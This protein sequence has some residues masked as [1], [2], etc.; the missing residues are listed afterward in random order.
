M[1]WFG[2]AVGPAAAPASTAGPVRADDLLRLREVGGLAV[3]PDGRWLA[4][5]VRQADVASNSYAVR[6]FVQATDGLAPP[7]PLELDGGQPIPGYAYG[8][9]AGHIPKAPPVWSPDGRRFAFRRQVADRVELWASGLDGAPPVRVADGAPQVTEFAWLPDGR[10]VYRTGLNASRYAAELEAESANGWLQD[11]RVVPFASQ[12]RPALPE[13]REPGESPACEIEVRVDSPAGS[14]AAAASERASFETILRPAAALAAAR[15][16]RIGLAV[17][18]RSDGARA[19]TET[20]DAAHRD[21]VFPVMALATDAAAAAPCAAAACRAGRVLSAGWGRG[22]REIW[23]VRGDSG[24][25]RPDGAPYDLTGVYVWELGGGAVRR[26]RSGGELLSDCQGRGA[27]I[28]CVEEGPLSP[29]RIVSLDLASG[30]VRTL[31]DPNPQFRTKALPRVEKLAADGLPG[32]LGFAYLIYPVGYTP[33]RLYPLI[34]VQYEAKGFL[35]GGIGAEVPVL[36]LSSEGFFVLSTD[37]PAFWDQLRTL[38]LAD[39]DRFQ[40]AQGMQDRRSILK[41]I[42]DTVASLVAR[43]LV[44]PGRVGLTGISAGAQVVHHALQT[45]DAYA[46]AVAASGN[47]DITFLA[48][49]PASDRRTRRM[50]MMGEADLI[51][52]LASPLLELAWSNKP[53]RLTTPLLVNV[54]EREALLGFEGLEQ[55]KTRQRPLEVR[56]FPDEFHIKYHPRSLAGSYRNS[57]A[58]LAFWLQDRELADPALKADYGRWRGMRARLQA[59]RGQ[60]TAAALGRDRTAGD[61]RTP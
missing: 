53:E 17:E 12:Q 27:A 37:K 4:F 43:G 22:E 36:P 1:D 21:A 20:A 34:V 41:A 30:R 58:W 55:L 60:A 61:G 26:V 9:V 39:F 45:S 42:D 18:P 52:D 3:S 24:R 49:M 33:G 10:L 29:P 50:K 38:T 13:C 57:I 40:Q 46:A 8:L 48:L 11:A 54:G 44:D 7:R 2:Q 51:P 23:F 14:R 47:Q 25:G 16:Q 5:S 6:W 19:W 59:E 15:G 28:Y 31:A 56:V 32:A 35:R